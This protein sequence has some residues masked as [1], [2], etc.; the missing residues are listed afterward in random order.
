MEIGI[1]D[2]SVYIPEK[3]QSLEEIMELNN[4]SIQ[5]QKV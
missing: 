4:C 3:R 1:K 5:E 2:L